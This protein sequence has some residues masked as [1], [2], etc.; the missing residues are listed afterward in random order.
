MYENVPNSIEGIKLDHICCFFQQQEH[1][2]E[3]ES[4]SPLFKLNIGS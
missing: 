3:T 2:N 4:W 1:V